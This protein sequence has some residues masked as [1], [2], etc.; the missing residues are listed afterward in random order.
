MKR[1]LTPNPFKHR[2]HLEEEFQLSYNKKSKTLTIAVIHYSTP[3]R[4]RKQFKQILKYTEV[5]EDEYDNLTFMDCVLKVNSDTHTD[6]HK[7]TYYY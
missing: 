1:T 2:T 5:R 7:Y 4:L 6:Y 3:Q